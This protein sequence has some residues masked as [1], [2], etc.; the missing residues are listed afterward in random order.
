MAVSSWWTAALP[1][2]HSDVTAAYVPFYLGLA[3]VL[4]TWLALA[5][6]DRPRTL[7][8]YAA[9]VALPLL[10]AAP[11]GRDL[12]AY[13]AQGNLVRHGLDPYAAGPSALPGAFTDQVSP[14]WLNSP[15]PYGPLWLR[16][17]HLAVDVSAGHPTLAALLLRLPALAGL[18][19]I[20]WALPRLAGALGVADALPRGLWLGAAA[21]LT[22]VLGVG[23]GHNDLPMLGLALAGLAIA[24]RP[25]LRPLALG[26]AVIGLGVMIKSPAAFALPFAV[27][28]WLRATNRPST[29]RNTITG[30]VT[31][32]IGGGI[33][34]G[35]VT[36]A[37]DLGAGWTHQVNAD[38]Q[39]ISWLSLPCA[40]VM[41]GRWVGQAGAIK[42]LDATLRVARH[43]GTALTFAV[44]VVL[45]VLALRAKAGRTVIAALAGTLGAAA[46]LA[47]SV[48]PWYYCW[49]LALA[50]LVVTKR[51]WLTV[52]A[53]TALMF[54]VMIMPSGSGL[55]S[56]WRALPII[57]AALVVAALTVGKTGVGKPG[58][59]KPGVGRPQRRQTTQPMTP[60]PRCAPSTAPSSET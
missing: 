32:L 22:L 20:I 52:L 41:F 3:A 26:A 48:Q 6:C 45:W 1:A 15:S 11:F 31:V 25:G 33:A 44:A 36:L 16:V 54:P 49:G 53:A 23:G 43:V 12:W 59:D 28:V 51:W 58:V 10:G 24:T 38:A 56:D 30:C 55:E 9:S 14:R 21:P 46:L 8:R 18:G 17:S 57:V 42:Q 27:P 39:W 37:A 34:A 40:V 7:R 2:G 4:I 47:P 60:G 5:R 35:V 13:A 19:L 29:G 50:G